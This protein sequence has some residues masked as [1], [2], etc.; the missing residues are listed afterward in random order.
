MKLKK[1][2]NYWHLMSND[3]FHATLDRLEL[4]ELLMLIEDA[5]AEDW[6][7]IWKH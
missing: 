3:I 7:K 5:L 2:G 1:D 4:T 6:G